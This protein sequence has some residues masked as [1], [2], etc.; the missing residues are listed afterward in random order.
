MAS[1][2]G[3]PLYVPK[4]AT[5]DN[6]RVHITQ[7]NAQGC[8]ASLESIIAPGPDR[9]APPCEFYT[10]CGSC[11]LQHIN[12]DA[13][14]AWKTGHVSTTLA[15]AG[16]VPEAFDPPVFIPAATRRR[17]TFCARRTQA[18]LVLGYNQNRSHVI[19]NITH[20]LVLEPGFDAKLQALR[21]PLTEFMQPGDTLDVMLQQAG[22]A[23]DL[24]L[25]GKLAHKGR[26]SYAQNEALAAMMALGIAR[27]SHRDKSFAPPTPLLS[28]PDV[29]RNFA[30]IAVR[31]PPGAFLQ[32]SDAGEDALARA[33][34][35]YAGNTPGATADLFCGVGTFTGHVL[36]KTKTLYAADSDAAAIGA[37]KNACAGRNNITIERRDLFKDPLPPAQLSSFETVILDPP[38]AGGMAQVRALAESE[39]SSIIYVSCNPASFARDADILQDGGYRLR[40]L[41][42]VDQFVYTAHCEIIGLFKRG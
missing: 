17:A 34:L 22:A 31:I 11:S 29:I 42:L 39:V 15:R 36:G 38:R 41:R 35:D 24:V 9:A 27:I 5:G 18:G 32:A 4:T 14:E 7:N 6:V 28:Q 8:F 12:R 20:C 13:Y 33:V 21:D 16:V 26:L 1:Y 25:T 3:K 10:R 30:E 2:Q 23:Y 19:E 40:R 37:L